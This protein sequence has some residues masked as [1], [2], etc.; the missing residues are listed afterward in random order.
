[1]TE[2]D[3]FL[4]ISPQNSFLK[5]MIFAIPLVAS[6]NKYEGVEFLS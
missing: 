3:P 6:I 1:M 5:L 2:M 4:D